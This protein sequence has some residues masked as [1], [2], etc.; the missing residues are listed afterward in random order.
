[1]SRADYFLLLSKIIFLRGTDE[2]GEG[3][4]SVYGER[5][6]YKPTNPFF[7]PLAYSQLQVNA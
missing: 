5:M 6:E 4:W 7:M 3:R 1:M 2:D